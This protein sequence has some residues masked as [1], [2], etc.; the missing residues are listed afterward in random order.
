MMNVGRLCVK[1]AGREAGRKCVIVEVVDD[2]YV[3]IDGMVKRKKCNVN[4]LE[5]LPHDIQL[6]SASHSDALEVLRTAGVDVSAREKKW[7]NKVPRQQR[8]PVAKAATK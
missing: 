6:A 7:K 4:H 1:T 3:I 2:N 5:P 8:A